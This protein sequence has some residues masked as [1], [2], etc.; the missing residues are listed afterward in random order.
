MVIVSVLGPI[1]VNGGTIPVRK[2]FVNNA[3]SF[4][5]EKLEQI[6]KEYG[7]VMD[8]FLPTDAMGYRQNYVFISYLLPSDAQQ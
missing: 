8:I 4:T 2:L 5:P 6:F 3:R 7:Q 1:P